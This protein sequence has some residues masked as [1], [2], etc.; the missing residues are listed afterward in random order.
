MLTLIIF[1]LGIFDV[2]WVD[3]ANAPGSS[4]LI[5]LA[6]VVLSGVCVGL[7]LS[8]LRSNGNGSERE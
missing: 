2:T 4:A 6:A 1:L 3:P 5:K 8:A 7:I